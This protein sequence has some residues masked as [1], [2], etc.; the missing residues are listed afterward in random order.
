MT[1][2]NA[3]QYTKT[4][5]AVLDAKD[6]S[7]TGAFLLISKHRADVAELFKR[8]DH[9]RG[10]KDASVRGVLLD[11]FFAD[12][13]AA[14]IGD[15]YAQLVDLKSG[16]SAMQ[17]V[18][19]AQ[20]KRK[21]NAAVMLLTR[22]VDVYAAVIK[23]EDAGFDIQ[24]RGVDRSAAIVCRVKGLDD[25]EFAPFSVSQILRLAERDIANVRSY[26]RLQEIAKTGKA[27]TPNA[28]PADKDAIGASNIGTTAER[29]EESFAGL[30][31][32]KDG[33]LSPNARN[34]LMRLWA[35]LDAVLSD[36]QKQKARAEFENDADADEDEA[37]AVA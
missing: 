8:V 24:F 23:L 2:T 19:K 34:K 20:L 17:R 30:T 15:K 28:Q 14:K 21:M 11:H 13:Q 26:A 6:K 3:S 29:L 4:V 18:E 35:H 16:A 36:E 9:A 7:E 32:E 1:D 12:P 31:F 5:L 33:G 22:L 25:D 37:K 10:I 27:G